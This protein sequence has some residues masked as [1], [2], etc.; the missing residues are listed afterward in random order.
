VGR[1]GITSIIPAIRIGA[2]PGRIVSVGNGT[3]SDYD[4]RK[5]H[6]HVSVQLYPRQADS[7]EEERQSE[8][9]KGERE[10]EREREQVS[11]GD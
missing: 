1:G 5:K 9:K 7:A 4:S 10:R 3:R 8:G 11:T 2:R 6:E